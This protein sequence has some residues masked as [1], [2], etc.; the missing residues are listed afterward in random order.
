VIE[1][2][3]WIL[4]IASGTAGVLV[5]AFGMIGNLKSAGRS[6]QAIEY[7]ALIRRLTEIEARADQLGETIYRKDRQLINALEDA[8]EAKAAAERAEALAAEAMSRLAELEVRYGKLEHA[9][10]EL[11]SRTRM[12]ASERDRLKA[13]YQGLKFTTKEA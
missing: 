5:G 12:P 3:S 7:G 10:D 13:L 8:A 11:L 2:N 9:F 6:A 1:G 4:T